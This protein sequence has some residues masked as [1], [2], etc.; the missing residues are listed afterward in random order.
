MLQMSKFLLIRFTRPVLRDV[1]F[2][3]VQNRNVILLP[4]LFW[5]TVR[6]NCDRENLLK[7]KAEGR[8]FAIFFLT[9]G[10]NNFGNKITFLIIFQ[11]RNTVRW[12][13]ARMYLLDL[14]CSGNKG[15]GSSD[16]CITVYGNW[17]A[18]GWWLGS[19]HYKP[20]LALCFGLPSLH[21]LLHIVFVVE[22]R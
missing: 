9:V 21:N 3:V 18:G 1:I 16:T 13:K 5:P 4:K 10:Q 22:Y 17:M 19:N 8:A 14:L 15:S 6:T 11:R 7:F 20:F 2:A 12:K